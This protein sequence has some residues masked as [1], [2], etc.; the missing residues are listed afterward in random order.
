M[1]VLQWSLSFK[2]SVSISVEVDS[3]ENEFVDVDGF[4]DVKKERVSD[5][6][7]TIDGLS[8]DEEVWMVTVPSHVS[9]YL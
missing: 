2:T 9:F 6:L 3:D 4:D 7:L 8:P 1:W 5:A